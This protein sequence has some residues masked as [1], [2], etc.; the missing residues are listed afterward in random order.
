MALALLWLLAVLEI[1]LGIGTFT[2]S[3]SAVHEVL[4]TNLIGFGILTIGLAALL[5]ELRKAGRI[6]AQ[7]QRHA[8]G[9][10]QARAAAD[11][12]KRSAMISWRDR[13]ATHSLRSQGA[14]VA[15][16]G[17][18]SPSDVMQQAPASYRGRTGRSRRRGKKTAVRR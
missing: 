5:S 8:L 14:A 7:E 10:G 3:K 18:G 12:K 13:E 16:P 15:P 11:L 17:S 6:A 1:A 4:G 9:E 2:S